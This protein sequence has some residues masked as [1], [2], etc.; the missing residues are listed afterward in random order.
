SGS[1]TLRREERRKDFFQML[2]R[3]PAAGIADDNLRIFPSSQGRGPRTQFQFLNHRT[4]AG[5]RALGTDMGLCTYRKGT[6]RSHGLASIFHQVHQDL[7]N[8]V[9][10]DPD[11][12]IAELK[13]FLECYARWKRDSLDGLGHQNVDFPLA[14]IQGPV[15]GEIQYITNDLVRLSDFTL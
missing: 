6:S 9:F 4:A 11:R 7:S 10:V 2:A 13:V 8:L 12:Q 3:N 15:P 1:A 14:Q 5:N